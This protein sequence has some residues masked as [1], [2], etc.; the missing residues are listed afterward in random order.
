[1]ANLILAVI[2]ALLSLWILL[3][4]VIDTKNFT[5]LAIPAGF[6]SLFVIFFLNSIDSFYAQIEY[7]M[8]PR[9]ILLVMLCAWAYER[10]RF[11]CK[12]QGLIQNAYSRRNQVTESHRG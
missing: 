9:L 11:T 8:L 5:G 7:P 3:S 2:G 4:S 1:M 6:A 12:L 10:N